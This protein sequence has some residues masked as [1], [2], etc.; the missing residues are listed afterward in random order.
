MN[1]SDTS[2]DTGVVQDI[3]FLCESDATSYPLKDIA[4]NVNRWVYRAVILRIK[5]N[6]DWKYDD[7]NHTTLPTSTAPLVDAQQDYSLPD[8]LITL[9]RIEVMDSNGDYQL[10]KKINKV[11]IQSAID[12][13]C[14]TDGMP[15]KYYIEGN[16]IQLFPAPATADVTITKGLK[17][18]YSRDIDAIAYDDTTQELAIPEPF[19]RIGTYGASYDYLIVNGPEERA[20]SVRQELELMMNEFGEYATEKNE[21]QKTGIRPAHRRRTYT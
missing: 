2:N 10:L 6:K 5:H 3:H 14:E 17:L 18:H 19:H 15:V 11:D 12:E 20:S 7:T 21:Q 16:S 9:E 8:N 4:R 13:Y 1:F